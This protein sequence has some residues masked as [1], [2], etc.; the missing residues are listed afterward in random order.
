M[1]RVTFAMVCLP[2]LAPLLRAQ[3]EEANKTAPPPRLQQGL[4]EVTVEGERNSVQ[5]NPSLESGG[6]APIGPG[7]PSTDSASGGAP[8]GLNGGQ[9]RGS[10]GTGGSGVGQPGRTGAGGPG[11]AFGPGGAFGQP[12]SGPVL[13]SVQG[14]HINDG[15]KTTQLDLYERPALIDYN[16]R[17]ALLKAPGL[18]YNEESTPLTGIGYRGLNPDRSSFMMLLEDG[19]PLGA[20]IIGFNESYYVTPLQLV[21]HVEFLHGGSA[22]MY[23]PQPGGALNFVTKDP[24]PDSPC[25]VYSQNTFGSYD[26]FST[27]TGVTGTSGRLGY[28]IYGL[29]RHSDGF[30]QFNSDYRIDYGGGKFV[31]MIDA[32][33]RLTV[34]LNGYQ[35]HHGEPGRLT[36]AAFDAD[37]T[38]STR[39]FDYFELD[40]YFAGVTYERVVSENSLFQVKAWGNTFGRF[41]RRQRG[42]GFGTVP[43]ATLSDFRFEDFLVF[44]VE[45]R[46]RHDYDLIGDRPSTFTAGLLYYANHG[47]RRDSRGAVQGQGKT[48][49][50][51]RIFTDRDTDYL[52]FFLENRFVWNRLSVTPGFRLDNIK[53]QVTET[54]NVDKAAAAVPLG[55]KTAHDSAPLGGLGAVFE[56]QPG[57][58]LY[59][60]VSQSYRP[61][62]FQETISPGPLDVVAGDIGPGRAWQADIGLRAHPTRFWSFDSSLFYLRFDDQ[63]GTVAGLISNVGN[64]EH[65]GWEHAMECDLLGF[66]DLLRGAGDLQRP[67]RFS[68]FYNH[69]LLDAAFIRG[70]N[71]G[72]TPAYAPDYIIR[73]GLSYAFHNPESRATRSRSAS[74]DGAKLWLTNTFL[75]NHFADDGNTANFQVPSYKVWDL[76]GEIQLGDYLSLFGGVYN[77][78]DEQYFAFVRSDG[79]E[80]AYGRNFQAGFRVDF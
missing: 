60:N 46:F 7:S 17:Q 21:D 12:L 80:P 4:P 35:E 65:R 55:N 78:F 22:L 28:D 2:L 33:S 18:F 57:I 25:V 15:K 77:L 54:V 63:I 19:F 61:R 40:R 23:G 62:L 45:P 34:Q 11:S 20:N 69:M 44:G 72:K 53:Q 14:T 27:F 47:E 39:P 43:A 41:S 73:S 31:S 3:E 74:R 30:R 51:P 79:I 52:S 24:D 16:F 68:V 6:A 49:S 10:S 75:G 76:T 9:P 13:P 71:L 48:G 29:H 26:L 38:R 1:R 64:S 67:N 32:A 56:L 36:R 58:D 59:S 50:Q 5:T 70:P 37:P 66:S 8:T 42:G